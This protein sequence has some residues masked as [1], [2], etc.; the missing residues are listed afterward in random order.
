MDWNYGLELWIGNMDWNYRL[1]LWIGIL[2]RNYGLELWIG[3]V[4]WNCGLESCDLFLIDMIV[5][6]WRRFRLKA[7][8]EME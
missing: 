4:D 5:L 6:L 1:E 8:S 7:M 3:L 2:D